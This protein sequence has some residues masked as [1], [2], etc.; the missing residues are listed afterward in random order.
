MKWT[1]FSKRTAYFRTSRWKM[2]AGTAKL[3]ALSGDNGRL[4]DLLAEDTD[5]SRR[6]V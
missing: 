2:F 4:V 6:R 5:R 1:V 3:P